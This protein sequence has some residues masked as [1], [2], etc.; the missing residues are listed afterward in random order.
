[1]ASGCLRLWFY[2]DGWADPLGELALIG[3]AAETEI[4]D[5]LLGDAFSG[6][7]GV[8]VLTGEAGAGKSA[9]LAYAR[10]RA[11]GIGVLQTAGVQSE[12]EIEFA[13]LY[14][15]LRPALDGVG[16]LP[17]QSAALGAALGVELGRPANRFLIGAA[18]LGV[19]SAAAGDRPLLCLVDDAGW[20]DYESAVTLAFAARRLEA[21]AVVVIVAA[22]SV[23][24]T[25]FA[26]F[27]A[28]QIEGLS[29]SQAE[30]LLAVHHPRADPLIR[31]RLIERADGN[32]LALLEFANQL[33]DAAQLAPPFAVGLAPT[34]VESLYLE[35]VCRLPDDT[36]LLL[37]V[38]AAEDSRTLGLII[39]AGSRL[40]LEP[41]ALEPA[42]QAGIVSVAADQ[43]MFGHP[44]ARSATYTGAAFA[45]RQRVHEALADACGREEPDRRAWH[46]AAAALAPNEEVARELESTARRA[47]LRSGQAAAAAALER[48][49]HLSGDAAAKAVR[50]VAAAEAAWRAGNGDRAI[51]LIGLATALPGNAQLWAVAAAGSQSASA[52]LAHLGDGVNRS[53]RGRSPAQPAAVPAAPDLM[54]RQGFNPPP[55]PTGTTT[56]SRRTNWLVT[57]TST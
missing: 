50:L 21:E 1:V 27:P 55:Q 31:E 33:Q 30:T 43:I 17:P 5:R 18:V 8:L 16:S 47:Q 3:R 12:A 28:R 29:R 15:L 32:P 11:D 56:S 19:L 35:Q 25:P 51:A 24:G 53:G 22:R 14:Q 41:R 40:G 26:G 37:L 34:T 52:T 38:A 44:L 57:R 6:R 36:Q 39:R 46:H 2:G 42:E 48:A 13:A 45:Q 10:A 54:Q 4:I 7:S 20:L 23:A 49:A 9:L